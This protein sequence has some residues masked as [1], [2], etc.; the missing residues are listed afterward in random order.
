MLLLS[1]VKKIIWPVWL[2]PLGKLSKLASVNKWSLILFRFSWGELIPFLEFFT[3]FIILLTYS[4]SAT[5]ACLNFVLASQTKKLI[6][7]LDIPAMQFNCHTA[8]LYHV[9]SSL[10]SRL[11]FYFNLSFDNLISETQYWLLSEV[12]NKLFF[13]FVC[14]EGKLFFV[15]C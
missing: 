11:F 6:S 1:S 13:R 3:F 15:N 14:P 8:L 4:S 10:G 7:G 2:P 9:F 12:V 5:V